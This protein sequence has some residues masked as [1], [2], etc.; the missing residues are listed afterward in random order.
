MCKALKWFSSVNQI[1]TS[2]SI[3]FLACA[4]VVLAT[5]VI[6]IMISLGDEEESYASHHHNSE[7]ACVNFTKA[8]FSSHIDDYLL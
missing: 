2:P 3:C 1:P 5:V 6:V 7:M 4:M 8:I